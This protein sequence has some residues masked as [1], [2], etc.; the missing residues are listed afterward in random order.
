MKASADHYQYNRENIPD[1]RVLGEDG[2][3]SIELEE[4]PDEDEAELLKEMT[5]VNLE[6]GADT[7]ASMAAALDAADTPNPD[8]V[9]SNP[10]VSD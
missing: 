5:A 8:E 7:H 2:F 9:S 3:Y 6:D 4:Q 10:S 1:L